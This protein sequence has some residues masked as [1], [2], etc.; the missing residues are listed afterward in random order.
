MTQPR[1]KSAVSD[2]RIHQ[3]QLPFLRQLDKASIPT[4]PHQ[5]NQCRATG[6][7]RDNRH[8]RRKTRGKRKPTTSSSSTS[9]A[10]VPPTRRSALPRTHSPR[11]GRQQEAPCLGAGR[12]AFSQGSEC[13]TRKTRIIDVVYNASSNELVRTKS[14]V[15]TCIVRVDSTPCRQWYGSHCAMPLGRKKGAKLTPEEEE[16]LNKKPSKKIQKKYD[17]RKKNANISSLL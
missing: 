1:R 3:S 10:A 6:I 16:I 2:F 5:M 8:Q 12:G 13:C 14:L 7:S 9:P 17:E 11:A 4:V 15:R